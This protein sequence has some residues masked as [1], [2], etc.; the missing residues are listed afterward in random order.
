MILNSFILI[1]TSM[2]TNQITKSGNFKLVSQIN[3]LDEFWNEININKSIYARH[4]M[5]SS[6]FF[7]SWNIKE[8]NTWIEKGWF[9]TAKR[10]E[11]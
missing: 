3:S 2:E 9:W 8:I 6:S 1:F 10:I 11:K 4:R 5:T 7:F